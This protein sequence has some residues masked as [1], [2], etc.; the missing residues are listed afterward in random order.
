[1]KGSGCIPYHRGRSSGCSVVFD[2]AAGQYK[3][4][5]CQGY[6]SL[7][8]P[9]LSLAWHFSP[10]QRAM[11]IM[12]VSNGCAVFV[13]ALN[14]HVE[15]KST[16]FGTALNYVALRI[17]GLG[18]DDPDI[19]RA[20]VNLHSKGQLCCAQHSSCGWHLDFQLRWGSLFLSWTAACL[21][22]FWEVCRSLSDML[23]NLG[24]GRSSKVGDSRELMWLH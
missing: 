18:P 15:D 23:P 11:C 20:R 10:T 5:F 16:V 12:V 17:L 3:A 8:F 4:L 24:R 19:V 9:Q 13:C 22:L 14:R 7:P 2:P 21:A 1:M 6:L